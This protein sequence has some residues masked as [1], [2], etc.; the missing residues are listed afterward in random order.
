MAIDTGAA[1]CGA[2]GMATDTGRATGIYAAIG[3]VG[4]ARGIAGATGI[5][6]LGAPN[7][8]FNNIIG[9]Y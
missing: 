1:T 6:I 9:R 8:P 5:P 2:N 3:K 7:E 4:V